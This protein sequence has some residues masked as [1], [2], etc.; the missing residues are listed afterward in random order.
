MG[1]KVALNQAYMLSL[2][3]VGICVRFMNFEIISRVTNWKILNVMFLCLNNVNLLA[4]SLFLC[5]RI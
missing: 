4:M 1:C 3:N 5:I 2:C